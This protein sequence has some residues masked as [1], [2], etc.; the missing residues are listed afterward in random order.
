MSP[1]ART[2]DYYRKQHI[3]CGVV[4]RWIPQARKRVDLLG[5]IDLVAV[6]DQIIGIQATSGSNMS[7]RVKKIVEECNDEAQA[8]LRA[9]GRILVI[10]W[11]KLKV[12]R[13]GKAVRWEPRIEEVTMEQLNGAK[14]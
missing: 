13:G 11:R 7:S 14:P 5:F 10:G 8:W 9:G 6:S 12:K 4:E 3:F 2:L 1:T